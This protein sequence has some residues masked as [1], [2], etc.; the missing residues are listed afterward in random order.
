MNNQMTG[1]ELEAIA[2]DLKFQAETAQLCIN[3]LKAHGINVPIKLI[4]LTTLFTLGL[5][6]ATIQLHGL[7]ENGQFDVAELTETI[8]DIE[9]LEA[10]V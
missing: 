10:E 3:F 7:H 6:R 5:S 9:K 2:K 8:R 4:M 1:P